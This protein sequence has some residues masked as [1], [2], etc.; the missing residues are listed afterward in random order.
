MNKSYNKNNIRFGNSYALIINDLSLKNKIIDFIFNS[1]DLS[2]FRYNMLNNLQRLKFLKE[3]E[4]YVTPNFL[5]VN[6]LVIFITIDNIKYCVAI[7][8][9]KMS[10]HKN[11]IN[12]AELL[13]YKILCNVSDT[14]FK[15]TIFD[16]KLVNSQKIIN[17]NKVFNYI[18][19]IKDCY[20]LMSNKI[21]DIEMSEKIIHIDNI[22]KTQFK[23]DASKNFTFKINKFCKYEDLKNLVENVIPNCDI[24]CQGLEFYP[25]YSGINIV[26]LDKK[27][28]KINI[29][30]NNT[31]E[32]KLIYKS[33]DLITNLPEYLKCRKYSYELDGKINKF[34][35]IGTDIT[36]VYNIHESIEEDK[37]GIAH[38]PNL[39]ISH[40]CNQLI[41]NNEPVKFTCIYDKNYKKWIP[42]STC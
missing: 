30:S 37:I 18:M 42:L 17:G 9:R 31:E 7:D 26:Y 22:I 1:F 36:D 27:Q 28:D 4:H 3:N 5:G 19:L 34:W 20:L 16:C 2:N 38:I 32:G 8:K 12:L 41:K 6:Y 25:K 21:I 35:L 15:G 40:L 24:R 23:N 13:M 39:K 11:Q 14:L 33:Y 29:E 10:Y